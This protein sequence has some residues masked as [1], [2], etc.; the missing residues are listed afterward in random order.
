MVYMV[1]FMV[2]V[3]FKHKRNLCY[4]KGDRSKRLSRE[5]V[6]FPCLDIYTQNPN[7]TKSPKQR[8]EPALSRA[9]GANDLQ[10]TS[11]SST[12]LILCRVSLCLTTCMFVF[13]V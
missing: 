6:E 5:A 4:C 13:L 2:F 9:S 12:T 8:T 3:K 1:L 10:R 11:P 7:W